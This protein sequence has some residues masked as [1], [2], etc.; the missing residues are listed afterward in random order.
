MPYMVEKVRTE[1]A[2]EGI[3]ELIAHDFYGS[4]PVKG[5]SRWNS[6]LTDY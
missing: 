4:Q 2:C 6:S 1:G 5:M 3:V